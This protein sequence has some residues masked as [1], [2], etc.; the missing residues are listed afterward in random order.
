MIRNEHEGFTK[1]GLQT[2]VQTILDIDFYEL[3][4]Y[5]TQ[6]LAE[7][8]GKLIMVDL[9]KLTNP[10]AVQLCHTV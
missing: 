7:E 10:Q 2:K 5:S 4:L 8:I 6:T 3:G 9:L 1:L